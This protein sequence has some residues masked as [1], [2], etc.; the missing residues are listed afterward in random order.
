[1]QCVHDQKNLESE[2][3]PWSTFP[4]RPPPPRSGRRRVQLQVDR[5]RTKASQARKSLQRT[6]PMDY[7]ERHSQV[8]SAND[9]GELKNYHTILVCLIEI[10]LSC[11]TWICLGFSI[12]E[13]RPNY[14]LFLNLT[15][16]RTMRNSTW[17][18]TRFPCTK[19]Q[20][21]YDT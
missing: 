10:A 6:S 19:Y 15:V 16:P 9:I 20:K 4:K 18:R 14:G 3:R 12:Q 2:S 7:D 1:M 8:H 13:C 5:Q 17:P 11:Q 21:F